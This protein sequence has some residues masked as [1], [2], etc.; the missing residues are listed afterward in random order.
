MKSYFKL[1]QLGF[2]FLLMILLFASC[3]QV[4]IIT[5]DNQSVDERTT[6]TTAY[7]N[8]TF[9]GLGLANELYTYRSG[10]PATQ[11]GETVITGLRE[12]EKILAIDFRPA[13][14]VLYAVSNFNLI[15]TINTT[16]FGTGPVGTATRISQTPF[17]P[18]I[19]GTTVAFDINPA[20]DRIYLITDKGQNL[21]ISPVTGQVISVD[22]G[23]SGSGSV[24]AI[25]SAAFSNNF[26]GTTGT[27]LYDVDY[28]QGNVYRQATSGGSLT[29]IGSTGLTITGEGGFDISR[30]GAALG[31]YNAYGRPVWGSTVSSTDDG[32]QQAYRLYGINLRTGAAT[33]LG[34]V[35][36]MIGLSIL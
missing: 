14:R 6:T 25:N 28:L 4:E 16:G 5:P 11:V 30:T 24:V 19:E 15:Y 3:Q 21:R 18:V 32:S 12:G 7:P 10:P 2:S 29:L 23:L 8:V 17:S 13:N 31:V 26:S 27:S 9:Y 1:V 36:P 22:L 34:K 35:K 20:T 33:N